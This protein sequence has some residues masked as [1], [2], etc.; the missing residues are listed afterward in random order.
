MNKKKLIIPLAILGFI[1]LLLLLYGRLSKLGCYRGSS[2]DKYLK[3]AQKD[4]YFF[5]LYELPS[6][7]TNFKFQCTNLGLARQTFAGFDLS[8]DYYNDFV[9]SLS[10]LD[11]PSDYAKN[12]FIGKKVSDT[13]G[14]NNDQGYSGYTGFPKKNV[15]YTAE[16]DISDYTILYYDV[17]RGHRLQASAVLVNPTTGRFVVYMEI[18]N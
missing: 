6:G 10:K 18:S 12:S 4:G 2:F 3:Y 16:G 13:Y 15:K 7:A 14:Y 9:A 11:E 8:G 5:N 17:E 1:I